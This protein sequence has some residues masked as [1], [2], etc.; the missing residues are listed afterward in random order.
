MLGLRKI[1]KSI[2]TAPAWVSQILEGIEANDVIR[3]LVQ[4]ACHGFR[5]TIRA[6]EITVQILGVT[7]IRVPVRHYEITGKPNLP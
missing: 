6:S 5:L 2:S 3:R 7:V 4:D 1:A